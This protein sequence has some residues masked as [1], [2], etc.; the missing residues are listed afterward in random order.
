[1]ERQCVKNDKAIGVVNDTNDWINETSQNPQHPLELLL[2]VVTVSMET[3]K[4][5][6]VLVKLDIRGPQGTK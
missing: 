6:H 5:V 3:M 2:R 4:I 1:M